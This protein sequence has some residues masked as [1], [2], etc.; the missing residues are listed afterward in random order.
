MHL[1]KL[2]TLSLFLGPSYSF[3]LDDFPYEDVLPV[4]DMLKDLY[5]QRDSGELEFKSPDA[6]KSFE[7][8]ANK[9]GYLSETHQV[10]TKDGYILDIFRIPGKIDEENLSNKP[11]VFLQHGLGADFMQWVMNY[12]EQS[13]AYVLANQGYDVWLGNNRGT[14]HG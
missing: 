13:P 1:N 6:F 11:V 3:S 9:Y 5:A 2:I 14:T 8:L 10:V 4:T 12:P 7:Q